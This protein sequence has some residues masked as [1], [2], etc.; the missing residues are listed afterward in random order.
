MTSKLL[1]ME[2]S[3]EQMVLSFDLTELRVSAAL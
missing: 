1:L 2:G 3:F